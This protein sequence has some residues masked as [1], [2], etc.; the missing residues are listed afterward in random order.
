M[1]SIK[2]Y[3]EQMIGELALHVFPWIILGMAFL[4]VTAFLQGKSI[5]R[6]YD[7]IMA[8]MKEEGKCTKLIVAG[9]LSERY[10][11][12]ILKELPEVDAIIGVGDIEKLPEIISGVKAEPAEYKRVITTGGHF[13]FLKIAEGCSKRYPL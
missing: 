6:E 1:E 10:K 8:R 13:E 12:E 7:A 9:C 3:L 11:D 5:Q 4:M 2:D